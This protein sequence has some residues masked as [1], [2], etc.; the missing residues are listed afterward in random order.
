MSHLMALYPCDQ[1]SYLKDKR[2]AE[3]AKVAL[4]SR[5]TVPRDGAGL[6]RWLAGH[7]CGMEN[8]LT[9]C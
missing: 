4:D 9:V 3:A 2:Y 1:I 6:G 7:V 8:G 5:A